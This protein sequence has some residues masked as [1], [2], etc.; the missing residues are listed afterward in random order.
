MFPTGTAA[1]VGSGTSDGSAAP[2]PD[3]RG[4]SGRGKGCGVAAVLVLPSRSPRPSPG[5]A[6]G[7]QRWSATS[8][9]G[10]SPSC[11][12]QALGRLCWHPGRPGW[13]DTG[14]QACRKGPWDPATH[15][16]APRGRGRAATTPAWPCDWASPALPRLPPGSL[17]GPERKT[18]NGC[19]E[20]LKDRRPLCLP[21]CPVRFPGRRPEFCPPW[22]AHA[23]IG[24]RTGH[25]PPGRRRPSPCL[26]YGRAG[27]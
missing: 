22:T 8:A 6:P 25:P 18:V 10:P 7:A 24:R 26:G 14:D 21:P 27:R 20:G 12:L 19:A 4:R 16:R 1:S 17:R 15:G 9:G 2:P 13:P 23:A 11:R 5:T 3:A